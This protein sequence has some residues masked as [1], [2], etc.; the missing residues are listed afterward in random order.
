M[1]GIPCPSQGRLSVARKTPFRRGS[2]FRLSAPGAGKP[3]DGETVD[4]TDALGLAGV[5]KHIKR[6]ADVENGFGFDFCILILRQ[7]NAAGGDVLAVPVRNNQIAV[8]G[9]GNAVPAVAG[10]QA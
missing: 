7:R 4:V 9:V 10:G 1:R 5:V 6:V 8:I 2:C 3:V